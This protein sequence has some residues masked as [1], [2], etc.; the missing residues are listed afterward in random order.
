MK[1]F[2]SPDAREEFIRNT[3]LERSYD[4]DPN[5]TVTD[6][7]NRFQLV[8]TQRDAIA[9]W[10]SQFQICAQTMGELIGF[11]GTTLVARDIDYLT[12]LIEGEDALM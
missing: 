1:C 2:P 7:F 6:P 12:T 3:V 8:Q 10:K 11:M 5:I 9:L 4:I